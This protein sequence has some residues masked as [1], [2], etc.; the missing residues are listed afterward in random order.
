MSWFK[1]Y[2]PV[3]RVKRT[4]CFN[5]TIRARSTLNKCQSQQSVC[6]FVYFTQ[7]DKFVHW[8]SEKGDQSPA[9]SRTRK[10]FSSLKWKVSVLPSSPRAAVLPPP[11]QQWE[12]S[13]NW[14]FW[15]EKRGSHTHKKRHNNN[16][17][18]YIYTSE[19]GAQSGT[20]EDIAKI[21]GHHKDDKTC[22]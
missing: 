14:G 13:Q 4:F 11:W 1:T 18:I 21:Y 15:Q 20:R 3:R 12:V 5:A 6:V 17:Y 19:Q 9:R 22:H 2:F 10:D 16:K 8:L 7:S